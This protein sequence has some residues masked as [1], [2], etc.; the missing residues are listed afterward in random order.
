MLLEGLQLL[1]N[2]KQTAVQRRP[3]LRHLRRGKRRHGH[4]EEKEP[5]RRRRGG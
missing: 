3:L 2:C 4:E 5:G 1:L